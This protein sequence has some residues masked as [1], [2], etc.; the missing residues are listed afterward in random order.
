MAYGLSLGD[1]GSIINGLDQL[2][3]QGV[4]EAT[5]QKLLHGLNNVT[6]RLRSMHL[7]LDML[8]EHGRIGDD[9][10]RKVQAQIQSC[11]SASSEQ[12]SSWP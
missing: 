2:D 3:L 4:P 1:Q 11:K 7:L 6:G 5:F 10:R 12:D 8:D 9:T